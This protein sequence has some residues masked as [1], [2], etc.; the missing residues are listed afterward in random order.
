MEKYAELAQYGYA[1]LDD[2]DHLVSI[3]ELDRAFCDTHTFRCPCPECNLKMY[4]TFGQTQIPHFRH[5]GSKCD[6]H[7]YLHALTEKLFF[8]EYNYCLQ[9]NTPFYLELKVE[10]KCDP[11][12]M[13]TRQRCKK[14]FSTYKID[15][16]QEYKYISVETRVDIGDRYRRPDILLETEYGKQLWIEIWV[17]HET[18]E[19]K[20]SDGDI[21]EI[22]IKTEQDLKPIREHSLVQSEENMN[23]LRSFGGLLP[24]PKLCESPRLDY[25][26]PVRNYTYRKK[27]PAPQQ[28]VSSVIYDKPLEWVDLGLLS[29]TLWAK[30]DTGR[31]PFN[32]AKRQYEGLLPSKAQAK[33]LYFCCDRSWDSATKSV[34]FTGPSGQTISFPCRSDVESYWLNRSLGYERG[35]YYAECFHLRKDGLLWTNDKD[36]EGVINVRLVT[37]KSL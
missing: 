15:L 31:M 35:H 29:C 33:E 3:D 21:V 34:I 18:V 5:N 14:R 1:L 17:S 2:T 4:A 32:E 28:T 9:S 8:D 23:N 19:E 20:R 36:T 22:R 11:R 24:E 10:A 12:C 30:A 37:P 26:P 7:N 25:E 16:T 27:R 13:E 6:Y